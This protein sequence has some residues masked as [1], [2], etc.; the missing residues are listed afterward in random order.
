MQSALANSPVE[1]QQTSDI[2][3]GFL[4]G[5]RK[6]SGKEKRELHTDLGS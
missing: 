3:S 1:I 4:T 6:S 5:N 2:T